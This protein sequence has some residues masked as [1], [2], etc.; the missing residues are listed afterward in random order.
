MDP[1]SD[2]QV[3]QLL[4]DLKRVTA[5]ENFESQVK[6][7]LAASRAP[8]RS[9]GFLKL[10][11]PTAAL[12]GLALFLFLSGYMGREVATVEVVSTANENVTTKQERSQQ[13][14]AALNNDTAI[15]QEFR[16]PEVA[17]SQPS[18][19]QPGPNAK[20]QKNSNRIR[21]YDSVSDPQDK[22]ILPRGF[23]TD[24]QTVGNSN[25]EREMRRPSIPVS[26]LMRYAGV[27]TDLRGNDLVVSS[28]IQ[29]SVAERIGV[30]AGDVIVS[31]NEIRLGK[32]TAFPSGVDLKTMR[33]RRNGNL[34]ELKFIPR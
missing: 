2:D 15:P 24:Q 1:Q 23:N 6:T 27:A 14:A 31:L 26:E 5:P 18:P 33:V 29:N 10:A 16:A 8:S 19:S 25:S 3:V 30:K 32:T 11:L 12:A 21:S 9:F 20:A 22:P 4:G 7:R 28:V 17:V 34:V 13:N